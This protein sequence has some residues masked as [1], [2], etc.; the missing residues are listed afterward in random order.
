M[1]RVVL[2]GILVIILLYN[3]NFSNNQVTSGIRIFNHYG[4][5]IYNYQY[6]KGFNVVNSIFINNTEG[7]FP[8]NTTE[9]KNSSFINNT[10]DVDDTMG[11]YGNLLGGEGFTISKSSFINNKSRSFGDDGDAIFKNY[12]FKSCVV[13]IQ[14]NP[15][16]VKI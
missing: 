2:Y 15:S 4:G 1:V 16:W 3:S 10:T 13:N 14:S 11:I 5:A 7:N 8:L 6:C 9:Y 12:P